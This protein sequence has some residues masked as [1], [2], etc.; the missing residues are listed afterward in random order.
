MYR[1]Q[2]TT[3]VQVRPS[4]STYVQKKKVAKETSQQFAAKS[5]LSCMHTCSILRY[6]NFQSCLTLIRSICCNLIIYFVLLLS[7]VVL[8]FY[9]SSRSRLFLSFYSFQYF[10]FCALLMWVW[11]AVCSL[12]VLVACVLE[13]WICCII[14]Q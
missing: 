11:V 10:L 4:V 8:L 1:V 7:R 6:Y 13:A 2:E 12:Y 5:V 9:L 14:F 3:T